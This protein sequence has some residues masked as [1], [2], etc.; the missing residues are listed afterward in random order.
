MGGH[1]W[2]EVGYMLIV[3][4]VSGSSDFGRESR[5]RG[6]SRGGLDDLKAWNSP[7]DRSRAII[8]NIY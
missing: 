1:W 4:V 2:D 6:K 8:A 5:P 7:C 3:A